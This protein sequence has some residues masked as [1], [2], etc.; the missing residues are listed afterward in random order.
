MGGLITRLRPFIC[1]FDELLQR[2]PPDARVLD[3]GCGVGIMSVLA[4][5]PGQAREVM[6]FDV[7]AKAIDIARGIRL[8][9]ASPMRF[10]RLP[11]GEF[12]QGEFDV[13][14]CIDVLH[15][16]PPKA[17]VG[18][19]RSVCDRVAAGGVLVYK[20]ISPRPWWKALANRLH[21]LLMARQW[22]NYRHEGEVVALLQQAGGEVI[23]Q[24]RLDRLWYSH[25]L[26]CWRK[27]V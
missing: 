5:G 15:H 26:V 23:E 10:E 2:V 11:A 14:L 22:V 8:H 3:V 25:V 12:P 27:S 24:S 16:V 20:D 17:Q 7:A 1:P 6:G 13:V 9:G 18:F 21:D 4:A 19:L